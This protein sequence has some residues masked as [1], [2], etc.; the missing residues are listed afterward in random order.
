MFTRYAALPVVFAALIANAAS[1]DD[2]Y[3]TDFDDLALG[4]TENPANPGH[5]GWY[6]QN[7]GPGAYGEIQDVIANDGK[8]LH[9]F[10]PASAGNGVQTMDRRLLGED[11]GVIPGATITLSVD[12]Y[13][14]SSDLTTI[15]IYEALLSVWDD[16]HPGF[17]MMKIKLS[18]GNGTPKID[19]GIDVVMYEFNN[20]PYEPNNV[21][22]PITV[23]QDLPWDTWHSLTLIIDY[24]N[25]EYVSI[26]VNGET[27]DLSGK[28]PERSWPDW[29]QGTR[30]RRIQAECIP[31]VWE[32]PHESDDD[33]YWD[34]FSLT[35]DDI[36]PP[37]PWDCFPTND[38][39]TYGDGTVNID[40]LFAVLGHWGD[41]DDPE[42]CPWDCHPDNG[43]GSYGDGTVN[44]DDL[45]AIL[46]HWDD[47]PIATG[48]CC[49]LDGSCQDLIPDD[50]VAAG[51]TFYGTYHDCANFQCPPPPDND[52]C[53]YAREVFIGGDA[54]I[55]DTTGMGIPNIEGC[56]S[57]PDLQAGTRWYYVIGDGTTLTA[58]LCNP[59]TDDWDCAMSI[60]CGWDCD[61]LNCVDGNDAGMD[62]DC[63]L[64]DN[65][66]PEVIWCSEAGTTYW[67]AIY[68]SQ[69]ADPNEGI[70]ELTVT[71]DGV[72]C[73]DP[74]QCYCELSCTG[75]PEGEECYED[76]D[77]ADPVFDN[78]NGGCND[79]NDPHH[80]STIECG[81]TV[82]GTA[83]VYHTAADL[84]CD[85]AIDLDEN[86]EPIVYTLRDTDWYRLEVLNDNTTVT[87]NFNSEFPGLCGL[88]PD[89]CDNPYFIVVGATTNC[90]I[91][92]LEATGL[93]AGTYIV[94]AS[95][96]GWPAVGCEHN[97]YSVEVICTSR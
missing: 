83:S 41:C 49:F 70:F 78:Y 63:I 9:E 31:F 36:N 88:L 18:G 60:Y 93:D 27:E 85:G 17:L 22:I 16:T 66:A 54:V 5:D 6:L 67:I 24:A 4:H 89:T 57:A 82:C 48:A 68:A 26:T 37:C 90:E 28:T 25:D 72:P 77:G 44:I 56:G 52:E 32:P 62:P 19:T 33:I 91:I 51:G 73:D 55:D 61:S 15:N 39:G 69:F 13:C 50:C 53:E 75:D 81:Q 43:G 86:Q 34:N 3:V 97:N 92:T 10:A 64:G 71:S 23:G 30:L 80:Y 40:D 46:G 2:V 84:D 35:T 87:L 42:D 29:L 94:W 38:D 96:D 1:A 12:F 7:A 58:S 45:F 47:C 11:P 95:T 79:C 59:G 21:W 14:H 76:W 20:D 8:A 74:P 65:L